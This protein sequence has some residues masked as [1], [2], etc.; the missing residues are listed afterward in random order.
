MATPIQEYGGS[1]PNRQTDTK[2]NFATNVYNLFVWISDIFTGGFNTSVQSVNDDVTTI[3]GYKNTTLGYKD[4]T[5]EYMNTTESYKNLAQSAANYKGDWVAN[6]NSGVGYALSD[7]ISYT[8][9]NTYVSKVANNL[10]EPTS[11]TNT[12]EWYFIAKGFVNVAVT[13]NYTASANEFL[14]VDTTT[15]AITVTLPSTPAVNDTIKFLDAKG[16][17]DV[18]ALT[19]AR[20]GNT[21]MGVAEDMI[22]DTK[23]ISFGLVFINNDWRL[24]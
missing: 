4:T 24:I 20:N 18:K 19:I 2:E 13:A 14:Q 3:N 16:T 7:S 8:D 9:G 23:N 11:L 21:I 12:T 17:F 1:V 10:V 15:V 5:K 22:V 6:Y